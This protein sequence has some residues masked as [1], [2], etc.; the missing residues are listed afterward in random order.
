[1]SI[2]MRWRA[3]LIPSR[4]HVAL[5]LM[6]TSIYVLGWVLCAY[7]VNQ[8]L[9]DR[10]QGLGTIALSA[11]YACLLCVAVRG[12]WTRR[13]EDPALTKLQLFMGIN[14]CALSYAIYGP[15][16]SC[17][18]SV[19]ALIL[20]F[21]IFSLQ[22]RAVRAMA[23]YAVGVLGATMAYLAWAQPR[24]HPPFQE[25]FHFLL[26]AAVVPSVSMVAANLNRLRTRLRNQRDEL[27][28]ALKKIQDLAMLDDL[29]GL[30]NRR[31][32]MQQFALQIR[33]SKRSGWPLTVALLDLD[34][35]KQINDRYGHGVG[36]EAL[37]AFAQCLRKFLR[38]T[39]SL[40]RWGGEEFCVLLA[41]TS[42]E[43]AEQ[44]I[45]RMREHL[46]RMQVSKEQPHLRLRF[47]AG[48]T[49]NK[50][51]ETADALLERADKGLY[52]AKAAGRH[53][54]RSLR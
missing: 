40:A 26:M 32:M 30:Y 27:A 53:C 14:F 20:T 2:S 1:M 12:G 39:D 23:W 52:A 8:G 29:T 28:R 25:G 34:H 10:Y 21:G 9:I 46:E 48:L 7:G 44:V 18:L 35:F 43:T 47:S 22:P 5:T 41:D 54:T 38:E 6:G 17:I 37:R 11:V 24:N 4:S 16:R 15:L 51:I 3:A 49:Q 42:V 31:Y 13:F 19:T 36:D 33:R 45:E 50:G